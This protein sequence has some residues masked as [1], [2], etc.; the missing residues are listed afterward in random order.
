M[1]LGRRSPVQ[2]KRLQHTKYDNK[3]TNT[4]SKDG[5]SF[6]ISL[7]D[8]RIHKRHSM[9]QY[10]RARNYEAESIA[11]LPTEL[12]PYM[13]S[14]N[15]D[16]NLRLYK[17]WEDGKFDAEKANKV[18]GKEPAYRDTK[19]PT[20]A[21]MSDQWREMAKVKMESTDPKSDDY[22]ANRWIV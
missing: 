20:I 17:L 11:Q 18:V 3:M 5:S 16:E 19:T 22:S 10:M 14:H 15:L 21:E 6:Y 13:S 9:S 7:T 2:P 12:F 4:F 8:G 1:V